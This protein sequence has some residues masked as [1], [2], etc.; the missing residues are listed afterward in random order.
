MADQKKLEEVNQRIRQAKISLLKLEIAELEAQKSQLENAAVSANANGQPTTSAI[1]QDIN[2][3][4]SSDQYIVIDEELSIRVEPIIK[5]ESINSTENNNQLRTASKLISDKPTNKENSIN[6]IYTAMLTDQDQNDSNENQLI[7]ETITIETDI[8]GVKEEEETIINENQNNI[9]QIA[10]SSI[11]NSKL[12]FSWGYYIGEIVD[13]KMNGKGELT[14][15]STHFKS[16]KYIGEFKNDKLWGKGV[17]YF[18]KYGYRYEGEF[19]NDKKWGHGILYFK[20]G[21]RFEGTFVKDMKDGEGIHYY[22]KDGRVERQMW[23][24]DKKIKNNKRKKRIKELTRIRELK[25][26]KRMKEKEK[27]ETGSQ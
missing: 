5:K 8:A 11:I 27:R 7:V 19:K 15:T 26:I 16:N 2:P 22:C 1:N 23:K 12:T 6:Q 13:Q 25:R 3:T 14:W 20:N 10:N 21:D 24:K 9:V 17:Y 18:T 4:N